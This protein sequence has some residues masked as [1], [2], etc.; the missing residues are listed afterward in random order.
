MALNG[1]GAIAA[2]VG[3]DAPLVTADTTVGITS[4]SAFAVSPPNKSP[5]PPVFVVT[6]PLAFA[7]FEVETNVSDGNSSGVPPN[8]DAD[9]NLWNP[10]FDGSCTGVD[11]TATMVVEA[12]SS[13]P[14]TPRA[15]DERTSPA[16][17]PRVC[18]SMEGIASSSSSWSL[19]SGHSSS[20]S[21]S[22]A[23]PPPGKRPPKPVS[24]AATIVTAP[25]TRGVSRCVDST[26]Q[27][28][29]S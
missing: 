28:Y 21:E 27:L 12:G 5:S 22:A 17:V 9:A 4:A 23:F 2:V 20:L 15:S 13:A 16:S 7:V 18:D 14:E 19:T 8:A 29:F 26:V 10:W 25:R 6:K 1:E 11:T 24:V 3:L